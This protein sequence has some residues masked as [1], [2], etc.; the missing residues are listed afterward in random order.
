M[1]RLDQAVHIVAAIRAVLDVVQQLLDVVLDVVQIDG[2]AVGAVRVGLEGGDDVQNGTDLRI[3]ARRSPNSVLKRVQF[4]REQH[5]LGVSRSGQSD[6]IHGGA[7]G[8]VLLHV[9]NVFSEA[10]QNAH[11]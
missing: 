10:L 11:V 6:L 7:V 4:A 8:D 1:H 3:S 2:H 9:L 5:R